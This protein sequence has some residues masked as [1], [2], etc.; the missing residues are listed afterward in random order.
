[1]YTTEARPKSSTEATTQTH[2]PQLSAECWEADE[3]FNRHWKSIYSTYFGPK[4][5]PLVHSIAME[6]RAESCSV[7]IAYADKRSCSASAPPQMTHAK[8]TEKKIM[9]LSAELHPQQGFL[10]VSLCQQ[11]V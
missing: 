10:P 9:C 2:N 11:G 4:T 3:P 1:M 7:D 8:L 6:T 5:T